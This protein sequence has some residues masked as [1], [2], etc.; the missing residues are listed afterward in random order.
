LINQLRG[1][2]Q[3]KRQELSSL[4]KPIQLCV[5]I[6]LIIL[7]A[8]LLLWLFDKL[9][10]YLLAR[11]YI[12][13]IAVVF[14]LNKHLAEAASLAVF[15][16]IVF[17]VSRIFS[18]SKASRLIGVLGL[19]AILIAHSLL[20]WRGTND[21]FFDRSGKAIKCYLLSREGEVRYL[22]RAGVDAV[23]G[24]CSPFSRA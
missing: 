20:L 7:P 16:V 4:S 23:T 17:F 18:F 15:V 1:L 3:E 8:A 21:Q 13:D 22:E 5:N 14:N 19:T 24:N 10:I 2:L 9:F 12:E 6:L 11:S